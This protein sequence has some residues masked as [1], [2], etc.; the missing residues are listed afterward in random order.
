MMSW[1][2]EMA[3][4]A[5]SLEFP[6]CHFVTKMFEQFDFV[7]P[8]KQGDIICIRSQI[9]YIGTSSVKV[10]VA[11]IHMTSGKIV[12][13]TNAIMVNVVDGHS[14]EISTMEKKI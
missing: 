7:S 8:V 11:A 6:H 9:S 14:T 10:H 5:A 4:I 12:F 2:D 13:D 3:F 1:A